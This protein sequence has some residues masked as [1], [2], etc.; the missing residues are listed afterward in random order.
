[1]PTATKPK[2]SRQ[3]LEASRERWSLR[4]RKA[5]RLWRSRQARLDQIDP[6]RT[7]AFR[8][9][10]TAQ[11]MRQR[12]DR[13]LEA[14]RRWRKAHP[15]AI[16]STDAAGRADLIRSEGVRRYA[17]PDSAGHATFG[18]GH[19][20]HRGGITDVDRARWGTPARPLSMAVVDSVLAQDLKRFE[21]AVRAVTRESRVKV[22]QTMFNAL[23]SLAFNIGIGGFQSSSVARHLRA[24]RKRAAGDAFLLWDDPPELRGR[25][26]HER[27][28]FLS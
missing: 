9:Y 15:A 12:R 25:R 6:R 19:L 24:G 22:T 21:L 7:E 3:E 10:R 28:L 16:A 17:Y 23:V 4:E 2:M 27:A 20:L 13:E 1:M 26:E 8:A 5:L 11:A 14:E 18:V